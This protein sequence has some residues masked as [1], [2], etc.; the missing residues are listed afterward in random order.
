MLCRCG[1]GLGGGFEGDSVA[2]GGE[3]GDVVAHP[4]FEVD[5]AGV[6]VGSEVVEAGGGV[7]QEVPDDDENGAGDRDQ[8]LELAAALDDA[9]VALTEEGVGSGGRRRR[10]GR[11]P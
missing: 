8:G 11:T 3:L 7:G 1:F 9:A 2:H 5:A 10:P 4:A 6:V